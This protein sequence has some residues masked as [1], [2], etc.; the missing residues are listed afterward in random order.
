MQDRSCHWCTFGWAMPGD[1]PRLDGEAWSY[2]YRCAVGRYLWLVVR[3][4][5]GCPACGSL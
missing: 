2:G 5:R 3:A 1:G 4:L